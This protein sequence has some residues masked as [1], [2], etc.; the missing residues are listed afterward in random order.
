MTSRQQ[1]DI[2]AGIFTG[3]FATTIPFAIS[4]SPKL[5]LAAARGGK[6]VGI[7]LGRG[8]RAIGISIRAGARVSR[9]VAFRAS[10]VALKVGAKSAPVGGRFLGRTGKF[11]FKRVLLPLAIAEGLFKGGFGVAKGVSEGGG[12]RGGFEGGVTGFVSG[13]TGI[14]RTTVQ[15]ELFSQTTGQTGPVERTFEETQGFPQ[16]FRGTGINP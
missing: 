12:I 15:R 5:N 7:A 9:P 11:V 3:A 6:A 10:H 14:S 1:R 16:S 4:T 2:M 13:F 8:G